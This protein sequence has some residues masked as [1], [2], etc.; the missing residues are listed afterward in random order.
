ML[1]H[2]MQILLDEERRRRLERR[3][4][5]TG[6]SVGGLIREAIDVAFPGF[7]TDRETA[8]AALLDAHPMRIGDWSELKDEIVDAYRPGG[9]RP[10]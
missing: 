2:R 3:S 9:E 8:G 7:E 10:G 4:Q 1:T 5:E 6:T